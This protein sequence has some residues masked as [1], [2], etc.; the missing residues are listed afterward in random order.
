MF[1]YF[2]TIFLI[3]NCL[4]IIFAEVDNEGFRKINIKDLEED[5]YLPLT[6]GQ[7]FII[8]LDGNPTT[9][10]SWTLEDPQYLNSSLLKTI[11]LKENNGGEY[12][13]KHT[14]EDSEFKRV[15]GG[16][17]YHF[18][19]QV[20]EIEGFHKLNFVY[21]RAWTDEDK[22]KKTVSLKFVKPNK[23]L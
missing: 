14:D 8:E 5:S 2:I 9:G 21:K 17:Y 4:S 1:K 15:G 6:L 13:K 18:K 7:K 12:Y 19:F 23:D 3:F 11:D 22:I 16:G 20:G 10:Y